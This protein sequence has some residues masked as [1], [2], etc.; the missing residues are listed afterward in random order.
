MLLGKAG[1]MLTLAAAARLP[2]AVYMNDRY[3]IREQIGRGG[4]GIVYRAFDT[5]LGREVAIKRV[6]VESG[7]PIAELTAGL[8][9]EAR[10]LS[11]LNHP[12][13]VTIHD[14]GADEEGPFVVMELLEGETL[15]AII[16][17]APLPLADFERFA[18]Q[19]LEGMIAAQSVHLVHRDLK[20]A[21]IMLVWLP[22]GKFHVKI[23]DFELAKFSRKPTT[24]TVDHSDSI[25]GS[26]YFMAPEQFERIPLDGRTDLYSLGAVFYYS[27][28]GRF[29]FDGGNAVHV[30]AAHLS[31]IMTPLR[32]YRPDLPD[33]VG[34]W[35][36]T[37][38]ARK[39]DDRPADARAALD[40]WNPAPVVDAKQLREVAS[41]DP[42]VAAEL[43]ES[44][45][46]ETRDFLAQYRRELEAG[47]ARLAR[48]TAQTIRGTAATLGYVEIISL[49]ADLE[50]HAATDP[51]RCIETAAGFPMAIERLRDA[52]GNFAWTP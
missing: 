6:L 49:A 7:E 51:A 43:L 46:R 38:V 27:L 17:R 11:A 47:H 32:D 22:S 34:A 13:I 5:Q 24:Q 50:S 26:I 44:F 41:N 28:T 2:A 52:I 31:H 37:L 12:N 10:A 33:F 15:D 25:L 45:A 48:E 4:L 36:E 18:T 29:P 19:A 23:L 21:N 9:Q 8:R 35:I 30:M 20:P 16:D 40:S 39:M 14:I 42:A 1:A 3:E